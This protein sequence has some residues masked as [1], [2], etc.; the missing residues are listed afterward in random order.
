MPETPRAL[1]QAIRVSCLQ[2][3]CTKNEPACHTYRQAFCI[4]EKV[5]QMSDQ[6]ISA[7]PHIPAGKFSLPD[8]WLLGN[9][10]E[11]DEI[12]MVAKQEWFDR[13]APGTFQIVAV[14]HGD[15]EKSL[16]MYYLIS[17]AEFE[18]IQ[19]DEL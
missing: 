2:E 10:L 9:S 5:L 12:G 1:V 13:R 8:P 4:Q 17:K 18:A 11:D 19:E 15:G 16:T 14:D 6:I 3:H 7:I